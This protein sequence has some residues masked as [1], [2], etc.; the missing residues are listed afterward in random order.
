MYARDDSDLVARARK[1]KI[2]NKLEHL[3]N[4]IGA[5]SGA[6]GLYNQ[7]KGC[8]RPIC[9][10]H[11]LLILGF[12]RDDFDLYARDDSDLVARAR[13]FK[14]GNK[15]EHLN[16]GIGAASGAVGLYQSLKG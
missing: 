9:R 3:N 11:H 1:L 12:R 13:K 2:G 10:S 14:I 4:G 5:A 15:L 6:V 16:N 8:V 7:L